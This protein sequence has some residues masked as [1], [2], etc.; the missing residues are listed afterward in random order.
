MERGLNMIYKLKIW[1]EVEEEGYWSDFYLDLS[2]IDGFYLPLE[3]D[4]EKEDDKGIN[5]FINGQLITVKQEKHITD[6][7]YENY[8]EVAEEN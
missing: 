3:Y 5:L 2:M 1:L 6:Y 7:L 4:D 8:I